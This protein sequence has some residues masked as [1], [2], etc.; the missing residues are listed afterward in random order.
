M[1]ITIETK[2]LLLRPFQD[3]DLHEY[4]EIMTKHEVTQFLGNGQDKSKKDVKVILQNFQ[5]IQM[6]YNTVLHAVIVKHTKKLIGH[7]GFQ[8]L[9]TKKGFELLYAFDSDA[10]GKG[11]ATEASQA[12]IDYAKKNFDWKKVFAMFYPQNK[13]S[14]KVLSKL[15][16]THF[17]YEYIHDIKM[18]LVV[19]DL[20]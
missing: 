1:A 9:S 17:A 13:A 8:P 11:Y 18:E 14:K 3:N 16:F 19:L 15:G 2:R 12:C 4:I 5:K 6:E 20:K 7:C 10:W